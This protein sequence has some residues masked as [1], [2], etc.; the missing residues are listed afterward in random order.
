MEIR[1]A[2]IAK[3]NMSVMQQIMLLII[4][5]GEGW[6]YLAVTKLLSLLRGVSNFEKQW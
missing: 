2:Y 4:F 3:Y 6:H 1:S 5:N